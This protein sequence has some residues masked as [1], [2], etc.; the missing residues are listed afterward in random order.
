MGLCQISFQENNK[1]GQNNK[2]QI[3][4]Q[5]SSQLPNVT[6]LFSLVTNLF[7]PKEEKI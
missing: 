3:T 1:L 7:Q 4:E 6:Q 5:N 2:L